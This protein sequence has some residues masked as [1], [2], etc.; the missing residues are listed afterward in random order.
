MNGISFGAN[1]PKPSVPRLVAYVKSFAEAALADKAIGGKSIAPMQFRA[2]KAGEGRA[3]FHNPPKDSFE[4]LSKTFDVSRKPPAIND[5]ATVV[6]VVLSE[7]Q[8]GK[9]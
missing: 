2:G 4:K 8:A 6:R 1:A 9:K 7:K 3:V 5:D